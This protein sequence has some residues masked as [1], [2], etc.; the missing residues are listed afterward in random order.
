M[1]KNAILDK[2]LRIGNNVILDPA[3]LPD[4]FGPD[5][6]VAIRDDVL[7]VCKDATVLNALLQNV[8][9]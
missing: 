2:S 5:I 8:L 3:G 9:L 4:N 1:I 7:V 6:S